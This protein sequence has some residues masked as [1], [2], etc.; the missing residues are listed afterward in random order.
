MRSGLIEGRKLIF[1]FK[2]VIVMMLIE[3][4]KGFNFFYNEVEIVINIKY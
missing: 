1:F 3:I 2:K 4:L